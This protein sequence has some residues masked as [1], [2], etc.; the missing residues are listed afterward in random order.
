MESTTEGKKKKEKKK[1][2]EII[3]RDL[4]D[5]SLIGEAELYGKAELH[6]DSQSQCQRLR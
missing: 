3:I 2:R 5:D 4:H 6:D 1:E